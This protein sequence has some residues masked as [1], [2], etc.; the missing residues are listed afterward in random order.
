MCTPFKTSCYFKLSGT[1]FWLS[2]GVMLNA[3]SGPSQ[4][5]KAKADSRL[6]LSP[7]CDTHSLVKTDELVAV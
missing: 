1:E 5:N 4:L 2:G 3:G 6:I 7:C